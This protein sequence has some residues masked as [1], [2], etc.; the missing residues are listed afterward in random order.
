MARFQYKALQ[1]DGRIVEGELEAGGRQEAFRQIESRGLRPIRLQQH[2]GG[3]NG[4]ARPRAQGNGHAAKPQGIS[5]AP[6]A[7]PWRLPWV[8]SRKVG[9]RALENFTR[10]LSSLL[11]AG[12]PL[13]RALV[14]LEKETAHPAAQQRWKEIHDRVVDGM[15]L[16]EAMAQSPDVFPRV[17]VAMVEAGE[18][19][20]FLDLV[21]AQIA[22]FQAREKE[23][24][25][26][27]LS[28]LLYPAILMVLALGVLVF[29]LVYFIP[30]FTT[31]FAGFGGQLPALT[32]AIVAVSEAVRSYG[33][34]LLAGGVSAGVA[35]RQWFI[36]PAGRRVWEGLILQMPGLGRLVAQ[37]AMARFCRMLGTLLAAGVPLIQGLQVARR[38]LGNQI[39]VDAVAGSIDRVKEGQGLGTSL[40]DCPLLFPGSV[41]EMITVAE[42]SGR[43]DQELI[44]I[45]NTTE[46][47]L[48]R[49]L[50]LAVSMAEPVMLFFIAGFIGLIFIGMVLPIFSLQDYIR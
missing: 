20:G 19:G 17:Y 9:G 14:I 47:D 49:Q 25:A 40:R 30:K 37:Y 8:R 26:K 29:L 2:T 41:L 15:S 6:E 18:T 4:K 12:V 1:A 31:L 10:L 11:A 45:A 43:L 34:V 7:Y 39:L 23:M 38:S 16:A 32:R 22:D 5:E 28:A 36:S 48:D 13:S 3:P 24:R 35:F 42:E 21:L 44:R 50:K 27:L 33:L 46:A